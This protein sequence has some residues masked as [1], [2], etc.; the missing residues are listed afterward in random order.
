M[1]IKRPV[2]C[3]KRKRDGF[4]MPLNDALVNAYP[5]KFMVVEVDP[6]NH[7]KEIRSGVVLPP[8]DPKADAVLDLTKL[9]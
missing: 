2:F 5:D 8:P 7:S 4:L 9:K 6:D 1:A 3:T